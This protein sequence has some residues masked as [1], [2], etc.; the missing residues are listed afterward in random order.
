MRFKVC[1]G[2]GVDLEKISITLQTTS[3]RETCEMGVKIY[4]N[5]GKHKITY[6]FVCVMM[7]ITTWSS[8]Q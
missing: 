3:L 8:F 2:C 7:V 1:L 5:I 6:D 4:K